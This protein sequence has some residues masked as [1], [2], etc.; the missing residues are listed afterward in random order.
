[1]SSADLAWQEVFVG[2]VGGTGQ[3]GSYSIPTAEQLGT[4]SPSG[5]SYLPPF[6]A[7]SITFNPA[8][9]LVRPGSKRI[10]GVTELD[11]S[12][13]TI[14]AG[15]VTLLNTLANALKNGFNVAGRIGNS[16][17]VIYSRGTLDR[18]TPLAIDVTSHRVLPNVSTQNSRKIGHG[19]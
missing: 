13:G 6:N 14:V 12:A 2:A 16:S 17:L 5:N 15:T 7:F 1:M 4:R 3:Y 10:A 18:P 8:L 11:N 9:R 19:M